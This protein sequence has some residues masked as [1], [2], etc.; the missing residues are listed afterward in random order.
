VSSAGALPS[1]A[2]Q[3]S[4]TPA[5]FGF[6]PERFIQK[7]KHYK[8]LGSQIAGF[9]LA[10]RR[11]ADQFLSTESVLLVD[12]AINPIGTIVAADGV[13]LPAVKKFLW[14][15]AP[16]EPL[17]SVPGVGPEFSQDRRWLFV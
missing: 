3:P 12:L 10:A 6:G 14:D 1:Q 15:I 13:G 17:L 4:R 7:S 16:G 9:I 11:A 2:E 8:L 5:I